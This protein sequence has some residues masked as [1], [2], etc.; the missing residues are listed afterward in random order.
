MTTNKRARTARPNNKRFPL[1]PQRQPRWVVVCRLRRAWP[2]LIQVT[3]QAGR[4]RM[5]AASRR[6]SKNAHRPASSGPASA[7]L[8]PGHLIQPTCKYK[9]EP[10]AVHTQHGSLPAA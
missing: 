6:R 8:P 4:Q 1:C 2:A 5:V 7:E 9:Q 3:Q 10:E